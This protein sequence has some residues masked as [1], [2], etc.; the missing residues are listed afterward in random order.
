M[1]IQSCMVSFKSSKPTRRPDSLLQTFSVKTGHPY[2]CQQEFSLTGRCRNVVN[3]VDLISETCE[4]IAT[5]K[6]QMRRLQPPHSGLTIVLP[7]REKS[8]NIKY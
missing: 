4:D 2:W 1:F 8:S 3:N 5:G 7:L 6:L